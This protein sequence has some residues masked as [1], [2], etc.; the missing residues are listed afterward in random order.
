MSTAE[1][2]LADP[3]THLVSMA[4]TEAG[5]VE[6]RFGDRRFLERVATACY[7]RAQHCGCQENT[8]G[9]CR[10]LLAM[11]AELDKHVAARSVA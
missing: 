2:L 7:E 4:V 9:G 5:R 6:K 3:V 11:G 1:N 8:C 10:T